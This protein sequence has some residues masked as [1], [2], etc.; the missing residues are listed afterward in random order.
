MLVAVTGDSNEGHAGESELP[1]R[2]N[3][4]SPALSA[5]ALSTRIP[6]SRSRVKVS[7]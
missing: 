5:N 7:R 3:A 2:A 6:V 4:T 1:L